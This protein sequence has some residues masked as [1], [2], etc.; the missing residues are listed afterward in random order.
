[1]GSKKHRKPN[2]QGLAVLF[3]QS[4]K[5]REKVRRSIDFYHYYTILKGKYTR[6]Q[7]ETCRIKATV[8]SIFH[9]Q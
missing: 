6:I 9:H 8:V 7:K 5:L 4:Y 1:M 2:C 3:S